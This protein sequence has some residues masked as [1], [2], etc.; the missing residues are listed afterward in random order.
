M[1]DQIPTSNAYS[2]YFN[3]NQCRSFAQTIVTT[4]VTQLTAQPCS[5][6]ILVNRTGATLSAFDQ[7]YIGT[8]NKTVS[9][10]AMSVKNDESF[11]F[12]GLTNSDQ[13][14][15][16]GSAAGVVYFRTQFFSMNPSR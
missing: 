12:R 13:L 3:I 1:A 9:A 7:N 8:D 10:F 4:A 11:T 2:K 14:S 15:V 16:I 6:V 5:E